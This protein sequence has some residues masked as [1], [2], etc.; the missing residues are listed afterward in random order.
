M[1]EF[2]IVVLGTFI[3][4]GVVALAT[5]WYINFYMRRER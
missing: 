4:C 5:I 2:I 1:I 3:V